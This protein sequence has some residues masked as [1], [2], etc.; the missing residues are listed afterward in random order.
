M[1]SLRERLIISAS[2]SLGSV[3]AKKMIPKI[4]TEVILEEMKKDGKLAQ[5]SKQWFGSDITT[6]D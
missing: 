6:L 4:D 5:I 1:P 2:V 3:P